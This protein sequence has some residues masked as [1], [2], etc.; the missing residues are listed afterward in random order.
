MSKTLYPGSFDPITLGHMNVINQAI[1]I[2]DEVY[3]AIMNNPNKKSNM[4]T[5]EERLEMIKELYKGYNNIKV[6]CDEGLTVDLAEKLECTSILRG[7]RNFTDYDYENQLAIINSDL[8]NNE[9]RTVCVFADPQ[10]QVVSSSMIKQVA[11][12][13]K[14]IT[15]YVDPL[16]KDKIL[17]KTRGAK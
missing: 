1:N 2:F 3:I 11:E 8:S 5:I 7:I 9:I 17:T 15:K 13:N 6:V 14:D 10:Y 16:I 4:F 12:L